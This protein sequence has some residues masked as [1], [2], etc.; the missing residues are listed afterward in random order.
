LKRA[1]TSAHDLARYKLDWVEVNRGDHQKAIDYFE[2]VVTGRAGKQTD[3]RKVLDVRREALIDLVYSYT[4]VKKPGPQALAY[5]ERLS[6]SAA[7]YALV[8][9]K[10]ANRYLV[11]TQPQDAVPAFRKLLALRADP[12]RDEDR[13]L[14]LYDAIKDTAGKVPPTAQ[15]VGFLVRAAVQ[16]RKSVSMTPDDRTKKIAAL[17][18]CARDL[19]TRLHV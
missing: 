13:A 8:L 17:E 12:E 4:E 18:E 10:L 11:K 6:D 14:S 2:A 16:V 1:V 5:F 15:D 3:S 19:S 9:D 7:S